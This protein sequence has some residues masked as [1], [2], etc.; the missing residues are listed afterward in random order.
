M[1]TINNRIYLLDDISQSKIK[2]SVQITSLTDVVL[3]LVKNALDAHAENIKIVLNYAHGFCSILDDGHGIPVNEFEPDGGL[4]KAFHTSKLGRAHETYGCNGRYIAALSAMSLLS[5][6]SRVNAADTHVLWLDQ[7]GRLRHAKEPPDTIEFETGTRV[8]VYGLFSKLPVRSKSVLD[9]F[10]SPSE[11]QKEFEKLKNGIVG[12]ILAASTHFSILVEHSSPKHV[13]R[14]KPSR[15]R[16]VSLDLSDHKSLSCVNSAIRQ[17]GHAELSQLSQWQETAIQSGS[18]RL[19]GLISTL[20][21]PHK[22]VQ[23][24]SLNHLPLTRQAQ[25]DLFHSINVLFEQST[26][27]SILTA[28]ATESA[29][30]QHKT[31]FRS[32]AKGVDKWPMFVIWINATSDSIH[33]LACGIVGSPQAQRLLGRITS[34][35]QSL[36]EEFL[37]A[38]D[39]KKSQ[40]KREARSLEAT[41]DTN[42][43]RATS[44]D[45][46]R[47]ESKESFRHWSRVRSSRVSVMDNILAGLPFHGKLEI[48]QKSV[49][50]AA[51]D[52]QSSGERSD[53]TIVDSAVDAPITPLS[54]EERVNDRG[55]VLWNDPQTGRT[56][57]LDSRTGMELPNPLAPS[58]IGQGDAN[59]DST[60]LTQTGSF[61]ANR[62]SQEEDQEPSL[63][64]VARNIRRYSTGLAPK[65]DQVI[66]SIGLF[67]HFGEDFEQHRSKATNLKAESFWAGTDHCGSHHSMQRETPSISMKALR[68][69]KVVGQVNRQFILVSMKEQG[70]DHGTNQT[71]S[72]Q[73]V[74]I[75]QHAADERCKVEALL[76][77][78]YKEEGILLAT[79]IIFDVS[80]KESDLLRSAIPYFA[81]W[82]IV[83]EICETQSN[84]SERTIRQVKV[85]NL[86][87]AIAERCRLHPEFIINI[88]R[89][90]IYSDQKNLQFTK[91]IQSAK[92]S[93]IY[94]IPI[95]PRLV[96][97]INSRACRSAI[98]FN[99]ELSIEQCEALIEQLGRCTLPFQCAHGRPSMV[100]L[101]DMADLPGHNPL[102]SR[103]RETSAYFNSTKNITSGND[104]NARLVNRANNTTSNTPSLNTIDHNT[105]TFTQ[106]YH[107]WLN[108]RKQTILQP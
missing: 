94:N 36:I 77:S 44:I 85:T 66:K 2:Y 52:L 55:Y 16:G 101:V 32:L 59:Q 15:D 96:E 69:A 49:S 67:A 28:D 89:E 82:K 83:Y 41:R 40:R 3:E 18:I 95:P 103:L 1:N 90:E 11:V 73:L 21:M 104:D 33:E 13:Y 72:D 27:G 5:V 26:F 53:T 48:D 45:K 9:R 51:R 35:M 63:A 7:S 79:Q 61:N 81:Q 62:S 84:S 105:T 31:R 29:D 86:P 75:D 39:Y 98:M 8:K 99:D 38:H 108:P 10:T 88:L 30:S 71:H 60:G 4:G 43:S 50:T 47:D 37:V 78:L 87:S 25:P 19:H 17:A 106:A 14:Y 24:L 23:Y 12:L 93:S 68:S 20:P 64:E 76:G 100:V 42:A 56:L 102:A 65:Q 91:T 74:L 22:T 70:L 54:T 92:Q 34:L 80:R 97:M 6:A 107:T 58:D 57:H 46:T